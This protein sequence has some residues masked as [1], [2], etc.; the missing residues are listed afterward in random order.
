[1]LQANASKLAIRCFNNYSLIVGHDC[2]RQILYFLSS[3]LGP[4]SIVR[5]FDTIGSVFA[6]RLDDRQNFTLMTENLIF[7]AESV[8]WVAC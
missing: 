6:Q 3:F 8:S 5:S 2:R 1:M 4:C 7:V